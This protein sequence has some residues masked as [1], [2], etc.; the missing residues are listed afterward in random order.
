MYNVKSRIDRYYKEVWRFIVNA[1]IKNLE[2]N[3]MKVIYS[4]HKTND[5]V[6]NDTIHFQMLE[7]MYKDIKQTLTKSKRVCK[8]VQDCSSLCWTRHCIE[9]P[10]TALPLHGNVMYCASTILINHFKV[11]GAIRCILISE[12]FKDFFQLL[13]VQCTHLWDSTMHDIPLLENDDTTTPRHEHTALW[14]M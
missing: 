1:I 10:N 3:H 4:I 8:A 6:K 13:Y 14:Y 5:I 9:Q 11:R 7:D 12:L 2:I